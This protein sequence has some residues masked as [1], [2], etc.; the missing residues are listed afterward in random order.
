LEK[1]KAYDANLRSRIVNRIKAWHGVSSFNDVVQRHLQALVK[2]PEES[3]NH[4]LEEFAWST[5]TL[6]HGS[7]WVVLRVHGCTDTDVEELPKAVGKACKDAIQRTHINID[8]EILRARS[9]V[10]LTRVTFVVDLAIA[11][12]SWMRVAMATATGWLDRQ[13]LH[14]LAAGNGTTIDNNLLR[15][16]VRVESLAVCCELPD[17]IR[18]DP[19]GR[20]PSTWS[21][22]RP[23]PA[24]APVA[25]PAVQQLARTAKPEIPLERE[26]PVQIP[27]SMREHQT[28]TQGSSTVSQLCCG[29]STNLWPGMSPRVDE[30]GRN[31]ASLGTPTATSPNSRQGGLSPVESARFTSLRNQEVC[32]SLELITAELQRGRIISRS[33]D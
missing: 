13:V 4:V 25:A 17:W 15:T 31:L 11:R 14:N 5:T 26:R 8:S 22:V 9:T 32:R 10:I 30:Q 28:H 6:W 2:A 21:G 7:F 33:Q 16:D 20:P 18:N 3:N 1:S 27:S 24:A 12:V 29:T 23:R 19:D